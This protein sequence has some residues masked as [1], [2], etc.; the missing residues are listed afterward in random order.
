MEKS[1]H[2]S[3]SFFGRNPALRRRVDCAYLGAMDGKAE[4]R[5]WQD[6][7]RRAQALLDGPATHGQKTARLASVAA[8]L[9]LT[10]GTLDNYLNA[11]RTCE[12]IRS[13][14]PEIGPMLEGQSATAIAA[15]GR[16]A[17][18]DLVGMRKFL[19]ASKRPTLRAVLAAE[20]EARQALGRQPASVFERL[21]QSSRAMEAQREAFPLRA[22]PNSQLSK[23]L[24]VIG[25]PHLRLL[26][27]EWTQE[28]PDYAQVV[29]LN[30]IGWIAPGGTRRVQDW[31]SRFPAWT[32][33]QAI[34][35]VGVMELPSRDR[36][37][38]Y[39]REARSIWLRAVAGGTLVPVV[40]LLFAHETARLV[41]A[42][43]LPPLPKPWGA[44]GRHCDIDLAAGKPD[45]TNLADE[46]WVRPLNGHGSLALLTT[47]ATLFRDWAG[48]EQD[49]V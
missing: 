14:A 20:K 29:G 23:G 8:T 34:P 5:D 12:A 41:T 48:L 31:P 6:V 13:Q 32:D 26:D 15:L 17:G 38:Q 35:A 7:A 39:R 44:G 46:T 9:G 40:I 16:W 21:M 4:T 37:E 36:P 49:G 30:R 47:P 10:R 3:D 33:R 11:L 22:Q 43:S 1:V 27:L 42:R 45:S 25:T 28:V 18:Y 19:A 2:F 24:E